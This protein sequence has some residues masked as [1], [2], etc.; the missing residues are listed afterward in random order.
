MKHI[1]IAA[2]SSPGAA[3]CYQEIV[4]AGLAELGNHRHPEVTM[5][6]PSLSDYMDHLEDG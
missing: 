1:G 2:C 6:T 4:A 3:L 5:H